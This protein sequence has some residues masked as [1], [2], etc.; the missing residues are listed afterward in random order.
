MKRLMIATAFML[1]TAASAFAAAPVMTVDTSIGKVLAGDNGMTLYVFKKD[2][3]GVSNCTGQCAKFWPP[4]VAK[5]GAMAEGKY[6]LVKRK[7]GA[8]QWAKDGMPLYFWQGD[9]KKG[10]TTGN[11]FK[12]VWN[13]AR[14]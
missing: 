2:M 1:G 4:Y 8:E 10:D 11:G 6:T 9:K 14:P 3:N 7:D 13:A 5:S 12:G